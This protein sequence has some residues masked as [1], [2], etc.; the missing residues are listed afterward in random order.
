[1]HRSPYVALEAHADCVT[2]YFRGTLSPMDV[3][4]ALCDELPVQPRAL[5]IDCCT[6]TAL[7]PGTEQLLAALTVWW[8]AGAGRAWLRVSVERP[9]AEVRDGRL[10]PPR[11]PHRERLA[12][13][14]GV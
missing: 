12:V 5:R 6:A 3:A 9:A 1:M 2:L 10:D 13:A 7:D 14:A 4:S 8:R 11:R